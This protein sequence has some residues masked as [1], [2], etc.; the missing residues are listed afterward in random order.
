M[1][2]ISTSSARSPILDQAGNAAVFALVGGSAVRFR[3]AVAATPEAAGVARSAMLRFTIMRIGANV[4]GRR[5]CALAPREA[6]RPKG[7]PLA[8]S[9]HRPHKS[10]L[11]LTALHRPF[12]MFDTAH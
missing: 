2:R 8:S 6:T 3:T 11:R 12:S 9:S 1:C 5:A 4:P 10:R 7:Q